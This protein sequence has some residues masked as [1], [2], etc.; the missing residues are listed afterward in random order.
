MLAG[1]LGGAQL[2]TDANR[3]YYIRGK[4]SPLKS[5][6]LKERRFV[7]ERYGEQYFLYF[8]EVPENR[9]P[10]VI[11]L[12]WERIVMAPS[13]PDY[14]VQFKKKPWRVVFKLDELQHGVRLLASHIDKSGL[15]S[16][17]ED[18]YADEMAQTQAWLR[19]GKTP[20]GERLEVVPLRELDDITPRVFDRERVEE[21]KRGYAA[22]RTLPPI[23]VKKD[24]RGR[25]LAEGN[26]RL[27]AAREL[28]LK[29]V[30]V[31]WG[32]KS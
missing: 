7:I 27:A 8:V 31:A 29:K 22:G 26:H 13:G 1:L 3:R 11:E 5:G 17:L 21:A 28:G 24:A 23:V 16:L 10:F 18:R 4:F 2:L 15:G 9:N 30:L 32:K 6:P 25:Y 19:V 20:L 12:S 14:V